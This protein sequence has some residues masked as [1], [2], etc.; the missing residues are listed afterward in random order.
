[1]FI[2]YLFLGGLFSWLAIESF[3]GNDED[4]DWLLG[5][6]F[7]WLAIKSFGAAFSENDEDEHAFL[8]DDEAS[9]FDDNFEEDWEYD[10]D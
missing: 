5:C 6:L 7:S 3:F 2:V 9:E 8:D 4:E 1:M 10:E